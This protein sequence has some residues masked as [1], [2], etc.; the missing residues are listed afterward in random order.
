MAAPSG[1]PLPAIVPYN[2]QIRAGL[3]TVFINRH[4]L[5]IV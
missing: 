3:K 5:V 4:L 2:F 1:S